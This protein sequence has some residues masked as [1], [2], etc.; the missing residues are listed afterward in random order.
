MLVKY[1][2]IFT[3]KNIHVN[4]THTYSSSS[5][6]MLSVL[7]FKKCVFQRFLLWYHN[8]TVWHN[9]FTVSLLP[10]TTDANFQCWP[11]RRHRPD[12]LKFCTAC[13]LLFPLLL[14]GRLDEFPWWTSEMSSYIWCLAALSFFFFAFCHFALVPPSL[15]EM[16]Q[17]IFA[18]SIP[19]KMQSQFIAW[20]FFSCPLFVQQ[21]RID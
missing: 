9:I 10:L 5:E 14:I 7:G 6:T 8:L 20:R 11:A 18:Y 12:F 13:N 16:A 1:Y 3:F 15:K 17:V 19:S 4:K 2:Y 21:G